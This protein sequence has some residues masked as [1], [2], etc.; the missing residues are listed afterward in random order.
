VALIARL[1]L[2]QSDLLIFIQVAAAAMVDIEVVF[3]AY[4]AADRAK[5]DDGMK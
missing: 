4:S 1:L 2:E 5:I 3:H